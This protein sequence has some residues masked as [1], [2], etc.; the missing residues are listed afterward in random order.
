MGQWLPERGT[1]ELIGPLGM[2]TEMAFANSKP[3]NNDPEKR[4]DNADT[5][6]RPGNN[7]STF[8]GD[9]YFV[10]ELRG[11]SG[12]KSAGLPKLQGTDRLEPWVTIGGSVFLLWNSRVRP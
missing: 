2:D 3:D 10:P 9:T 8:R 12:G 4:P 7:S 6:N 11:L 5:G 1:T